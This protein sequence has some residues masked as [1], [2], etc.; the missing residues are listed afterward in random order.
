MKR[1]LKW[2]LIIIGILAGILLVAAI[3]IYFASEAR[4]NRTY[5]APEVSLAIPSDEASLERGKHLVTSISVC[6]DCHGPDLGG[7]VFIDDPALGLIVAP[8]L[9]RGKNGLGNER[10]DAD[11]LRVLRYG[12]KPNG[13]SVVV[14][15]ADD[16]THLS[17]QDLAAVVAYVRSMPAVDSNLPEAI[18]RPMGR[19]L[20]ALDQLP[21]FIADRIDFNV[22]QPAQVEPAVDIQYGHYLANAAGCTGCHGPGLSGGAIPGA[23]PDFPQAANL[24]P[25]G[26]L[27]GWSEG[28][29]LTLIRTGMKPS[30]TLLKE[31][32]PYKLYANMTD[33]ELR[34]I[35]LFVKSVPAKPFGNR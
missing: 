21:V 5:Q 16:Y 18:Y 19:I 15:P 30:G 29:F 4:I 12:V 23:P 35:W 28:D 14:M 24:T 9:T 20:T 6:I 1:F 10:S 11:L 32:M 25:G 8:N 31:Q 3:A 2:L 27:V 33:D 22:E 13:Q 7:K 26:E 34:A 17:D